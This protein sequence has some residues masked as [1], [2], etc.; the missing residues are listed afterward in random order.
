MNNNS[1]NGPVYP[2]WLRP[3]I[4]V[5]GAAVLLGIGYFIGSTFFAGPQTTPVAEAPVE[6]TRTLV[7]TFTPSPVPP[8]ATNTAL[9]TNTTA[10]LPTA[11]PPSATPIL[12]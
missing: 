10:P 7:P 5:G 6:L 4:F 11:A 9:P 3:A 1:G 2:S 12:V 8:T